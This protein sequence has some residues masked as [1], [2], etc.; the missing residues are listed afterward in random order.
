[1]MNRTVLAPKGQDIFFFEV[2]FEP[3][4]EQKSVPIDKKELQKLEDEAEK[5]EKHIDNYIG[6]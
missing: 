1:M 2:M 6:K 5:Q 4:E 3:D